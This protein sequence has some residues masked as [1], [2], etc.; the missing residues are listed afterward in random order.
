MKDLD[1]FSR[2]F[3][4]SSRL[5]SAATALVKLHGGQALDADDRENLGWAGT[6]LSAVSSTTSPPGASGRGGDLSVNVTYVRPSFYSALQSVEPHLKDED[7]TAETD[8]TS[9]LSTTYQFLESSSASSGSNFS[10][11][12]KMAKLLL[13][14]LSKAL[15]LRISDNHAPLTLNDSSFLVPS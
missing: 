1:E 10:R 12:Y 6:F 4:A 5:Q 11:G 15:L 7:V 9:F 3:E 8:L 2:L 13:E 14:E